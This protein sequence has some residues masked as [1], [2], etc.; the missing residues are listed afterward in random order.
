MQRLRGAVRATNFV[1]GMASLARLEIES[2]EVF[3]EKADELEKNLRKG[4]RS[5]DEFGAAPRPKAE[6]QFDDDGSKKRPSLSRSDFLKYKMVR[7]IE[8][9]VPPLMRWGQEDSP[10]MELPD[11]RTVVYNT[12]LDAIL[13][14]KKE[15]RLETIA[16]RAMER[17][18]RMR[19]VSAAR[20]ALRNQRAA[21]I[22]D[23]IRVRP[24]PEPDPAEFVEAKWLTILA[25]I[26]YA[27]R[28]AEEWRVR[29]MSHDERIA[30]VTEAI[31]TI[32][33]K[34]ISRRGDFLHRTVLVG[35][36]FMDERFATRAKMI[37]SIVKT[38]VM[39]RHMR[40]SSAV[41]VSCMTEWRSVGRLVMQLFRFSARIKKV[42]RWWRRTSQRLQE[43]I[44]K[45]SSQWVRLEQAYLARQIRREEKLAAREAVKAAAAA[46][47]KSVGSIK[48]TRPKSSFNPYDLTLEE[49]IEV[50]SVKEAHRMEFIYHELRA[51]RYL[52]LPA[53]FLYA[54]GV[55]KWK[56]DMEEWRER[57]KILRAL[58]GETDV[59]HMDRRIFLLPP[60]RPSHMPSDADVMDMLDRARQKPE[61]GGWTV[62]EY[63]KPLQAPTKKAPRK[64]SD[65]TLAAGPE[66]SELQRLG[67]DPRQMPGFHGGK[68]PE[69]KGYGGPLAVCSPTP[70]PRPLGA[71]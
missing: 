4:K 40:K 2:P 47:A 61:G 66:D 70:T 12:T 33:L 54:E 24:E 63:P 17:D 13:S 1:G 52:L 57:R 64:R 37:A 32:R 49:L 20:K 28:M 45:V 8:P 7:R 23:T 65:S 67:L 43:A 58:Q 39:R 50:K 29:K 44:D 69:T 27:T 34:R 51:R 18:F 48:E 19:E 60:T 38:R 62:V 53:L 41:I 26:G 15:E 31:N 56:E 5:M 35:E 21:N 11:Q 55:R 6:D 14:A 42:Q 25:V 22:L 46:A 10:P 9:P 68:P 59:G 16:S 71:V 3:E 36:C 30:Y